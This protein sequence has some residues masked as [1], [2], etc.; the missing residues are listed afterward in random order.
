MRRLSSIVALAA[1]LAL[2]A[3]VPALAAPAPAGPGIALALVHTLPGPG[4]DPYV[5]TGTRLAVAGTVR[6]YVPGQSVIV[7]FLRGRRE[8]K[9][10]TV[11]IA[12]GPGGSGRFLLGYTP[13]RAGTVTVTAEHRATTAMP[14]LTSKAARVVAFRAVTGFGDR[15]LAV[16]VLQHAL[17]RLHYAVPGN[18]VYDDSTGLAVLALR[19]VLG[20]DR[21]EDADGQVFHLLAEGA[22]AFHVRYRGDGKH[23]EADLTRQVLVLIEPHGVVHDI[24]P[25]SSGKPSTPTVIGRFR[26]YLKTPGYNSEGMYYS[27]YF[28]GGYAIHGYDPVPTY[29]ASHGCLRVPISDALSIYGWVK[30]GDRVDVYYEGG[31]GSKNVNSHAG[32]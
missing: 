25:L 13:P 12:P 14:E 20:L 10:A 29:P 26:V 3:A 23:V 7:R 11:R 16:Q 8:V 30:A 31:G 17:G 24:Y 9:I 28:I 15:G 4:H 6:P 1:A 5:P 19:K 21:T 32:P 22:G 18:G 27:N 2:A